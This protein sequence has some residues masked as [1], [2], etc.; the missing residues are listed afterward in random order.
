M[1]KE[2]IKEIH[3]YQNSDYPMSLEWYNDIL[4][5]CKQALSVQNPEKI[6]KL[7]LQRIAKQT[8]LTGET[9]EGEAVGN[10]W[11]VAVA[12]QALASINQPDE[13]GR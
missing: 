5:K 3:A 4:G 11:E 12:I 1:N 13:E 2:L 9:K 8:P 6:M 7:A 10:T